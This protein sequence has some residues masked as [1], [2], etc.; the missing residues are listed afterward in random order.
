MFA[1]SEPFKGVQAGF[2]DVIT[3]SG[4]GDCGFNFTV[5]GT[6]LVFAHRHPTKGQLTTGICSRTS[7]VARAGEE[8]KRLRRPAPSLSGPALLHGRVI[9]SEYQT[10]RTPR[11][12]EPFAGAPLRLVGPAG[13]FETRASSDGRYEFRVPVGRYRLS[14]ETGE[15][16][17]SAPDSSP[18]IDVRVVEAT[19]CAPIDIQ[20]KSNGRLRGRLVDA[21][22]RG[23]P[24]LS[25]DVADRMRADSLDTISPVARTMTDADDRFR[26][27]RLAPGDYAIGLTLTR[28]PRR[29]DADFAVRFGSHAT[30]LVGFDANTDANIDAGVIRLPTDVNI[31]Q[32]TGWVLDDA[33][34][35]VSGAEVRVESPGKDLGV[36][37]EPVLSDPN[38]RFVISVLAGRL[39][40]LV[41]EH[42]SAAGGRVTYR[43][44]RSPTFD[45]ANEYAPFTLILKAR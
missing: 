35:P 9:R 7:L 36:S 20:I 31:R 33:S 15:Q 24:F 45:A 27:E 1:V 16:F 18:G 38:G 40:Q 11:L 26:F 42:R 34:A 22:G 21:A 19:P 6:Y 39:H 41:A 37:S 3:G 12:N 13:A 10:L 32:V 4:G 30:F 28:Y 5:G 25:L 44:S 23:V 29:R 8:L 17:Y 14:V 43:L 2:A